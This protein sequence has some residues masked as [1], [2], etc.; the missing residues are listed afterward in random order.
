MPSETFAAWQLTFRESGSY[1]SCAYGLLPA[2]DRCAACG[3]ASSYGG[4]VD[5]K[6]SSLVHLWMTVLLRRRCRAVG[7]RRA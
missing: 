7:L 6:R 5:E 3:L 2:G 4:Y 1:A